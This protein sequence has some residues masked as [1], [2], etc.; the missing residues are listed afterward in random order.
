[1]SAMAPQTPMGQDMYSAF[2]KNATD[3]TFSSATN[4]YNDGKTYSNYWDST[5]G[6]DEFEK[7]F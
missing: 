3:K 4:N 1:M 5:K 7:R 2:F 6:T